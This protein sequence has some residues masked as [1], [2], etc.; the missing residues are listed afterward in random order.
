[1]VRVHPGLLF[2]TQNDEVRSEK[3]EVRRPKQ[4]NGRRG[5]PSSDRHFGRHAMNVSASLCDLRGESLNLRFVFVLRT[6]SF[7]LFI[8]P[9]GAAWSARRPVKAKI[10]GSN[11]AG[12]AAARYANR[13]SDEAQTFAIVCGFDSHS[14]HL[15]IPVGWALVSLSGRNPLAVWLCRFNSCPADS[16]AS[17]SFG[18]SYFALCTFC[19]GP[20]VYR[21]RTAAPQAAGAGSIPARVASKKYGQVV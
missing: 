14:R 13:E 19:S 18:S 4:R 11:P 21:L 9:R 5:P 10:A 2:L 15:E 3:S 12:D 8:R 7:V 17:S 1:M 6:W 20:F 16:I